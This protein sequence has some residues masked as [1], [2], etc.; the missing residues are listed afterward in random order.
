MRA[1]SDIRPLA[2]AMY[3]LSLY[4]SE[5][6]MKN[7]QRAW[8]TS[9]LHHSSASNCDGFVAT[10]QV[11][12]DNIYVRDLEFCWIFGWIEKITFKQLK[13]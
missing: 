13:Y 2:L 12:F 5:W 9:R 1:S 8:L 10:W 4:K 7:S 6:K 3:A 11:E